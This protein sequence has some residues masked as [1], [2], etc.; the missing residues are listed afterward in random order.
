MDRF[1]YLNEASYKEVIVP[2]TERIKNGDLHLIWLTFMGTPYAMSP[3]HQVPFMIFENED[4]TEAYKISGLFNTGQLNWF[5][6]KGV[7]NRDSKQAA[8]EFIAEESFGPKC[9]AIIN[10]Y[11]I[12]DA[13]RELEQWFLNVCEPIITEQFWKPRRNAGVNTYFESTWYKPGDLNVKGV[14]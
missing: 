13:F 11:K 10:Q 9:G 12:P 2:I 14:M 8:P 3:G 6:K 5:F 1:N 7:V 4:G